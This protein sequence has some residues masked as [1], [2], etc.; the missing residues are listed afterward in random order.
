M[1]NVTEFEAP[2]QSPTE[3]RWRVITCWPI[4]WVR[5]TRASS[6]VGDLEISVTLTTRA[7]N[8]WWGAYVGLELRIG[9]HRKCW[10][11]TFRISRLGD[12]PAEQV[13]VEGGGHDVFAP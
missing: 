8:P 12:D 9:D 7:A 4:P 2:G 11:M 1:H 10:W 3:P 13:A 6:H 5:E